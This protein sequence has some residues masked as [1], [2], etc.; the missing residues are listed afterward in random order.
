M[1]DALRVREVV[2]AEDE[3]VDLHERSHHFE[4]RL[5]LQ[6]SAY[7]DEAPQVG[8]QFGSLQRDPLMAAHHLYLFEVLEVFSRF[9]HGVVGD[10]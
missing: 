6:A 8:K 10:G 9:V 2:L 4:E 5:P 7:Q 3:L 1:L